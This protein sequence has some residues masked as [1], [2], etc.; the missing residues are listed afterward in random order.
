MSGKPRV[1]DL[2]RVDRKY[3]NTEAAGKLALVVKTMGIE[4]VVQPFSEHVLHGQGKPW[5]FPREYLEVISA[6]R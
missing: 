6:A 3:P 1:G 2:V 4:C 5:W